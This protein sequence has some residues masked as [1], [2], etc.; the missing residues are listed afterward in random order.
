MNLPSSAGQG[1]VQERNLKK[2]LKDISLAV[3]K[4]IY[5]I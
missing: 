2:L 5:H 4:D 1:G 3:E